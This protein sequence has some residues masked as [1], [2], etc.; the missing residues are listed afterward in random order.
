MIKTTTQVPN[1]PQS[2]ERTKWTQKSTAKA[3][4]TEQTLSKH[5]LKWYKPK[6]AHCLLKQ[7]NKRSQQ[8]Q[9]DFNKAQSLIK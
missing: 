5:P 4:K 1:E 3:W 6:R 8:F 2:G 7:R 9:E